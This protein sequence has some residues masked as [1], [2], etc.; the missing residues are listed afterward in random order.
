MH[1]LTYSFTGLVEEVLLSTKDTEEM[2]NVYEALC[3]AM[4]SYKTPFEGTASFRGQGK[5]RVGLSSGQFLLGAARQFLNA[6]R[7]C[8]TQRVLYG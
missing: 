7:H 5:E 2:K 1:I 3:A 6:K 4:K 8:T